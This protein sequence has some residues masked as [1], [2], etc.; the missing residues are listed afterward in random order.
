[1]EEKGQKLINESLSEETLSQID[2][3]NIVEYSYDIPIIHAVAHGYYVVD[4]KTGERLAF[5]ACR[6]SKDET[7]LA[8]V[9][10]FAKEHG[11]STN[12]IRI[13]GHNLINVRKL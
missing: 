3:G 11:I 5:A 10:A 2:G 6:G 12:I 9:Q 7:A 4:D 8:K 13:Q 1:M